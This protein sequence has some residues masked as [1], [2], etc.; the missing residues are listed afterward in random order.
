LR[1]TRYLHKAARLKGGE[2]ATSFSG[3]KRTFSALVQ[4]VAKLAGGLRSAGVSDG[5]RVAILA[6]NSDNYFELL[7]AT[8]WAGGVAAPLNTRWSTDEIRAAIEDS[9][10]RVFVYDEYFEDLAADLSGEI[11]PSLQHRFLMHSRQ[12]DSSWETFIATSEAVDDAHRGGDDLALL[13]FTGGTTGRSKGVMLSHGNLVSASVSQAAIG[14]GTRGN[15]YLH[16]APMFHMADVQLMVNHLLSGGCH[17]FVPRF[18]PGEVL[19]CIAS[20]SISDVLL[21]PTMIHALLSHPDF[22]RTNLECLQT[23]FYGAAPM[24]A[25]LL[26]KVILALPNC[27]LIQGYG[28][29]ETCLAT[30]LPAKC[31]QASDDPNARKRLSSAG[32]EMALSEVRITDMD[33]RELAAGEVG[34]IQVSGPSVMLGY[35]NAPD[36]TAEVKKDGWMCTG[37]L[38]YRDEDGFVYIVDRLKDMIVT[39]GENVFSTEVEN[40]LSRHP[41]VSQ[42][43]VIG[44]PDDKWGERV[45]AVLVCSASV[46]TAELIRFCH[47][48]L[49]PYKCPKSISVIDAMPLSP[50]GKILKTALREHLSNIQHE[51]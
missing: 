14:C 43:A 25:A 2:I 31:H 48:S 1:I 23:I 39:G 44:L 32:L 33:G 30:M 10:A 49:S 24:P 22:A 8:L 7:L 9:S 5:E 45:H 11:S 38:A 19:R 21:V 40:V 46:D 12:G 36:K 6:S 16:A 51:Q 26:E 3:R 15:A 41:A 18:E 20:D 27:Q 47:A 29:T 34:E 13:L 28:M 17:S 37:D 4:R 35:W 42:C 50:A